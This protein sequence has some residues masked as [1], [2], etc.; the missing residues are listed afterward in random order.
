M[1]GIHWSDSWVEWMRHIVPELDGSPIYVRM[2][3]EMPHVDTSG[4]QACTHSN[5][6]LKMRDCLEERGQWLGRGG[7]ILV[8][9]DFHQ[10]GYARQKEVLLHELSHVVASWFCC[11]RR[12]EAEFSSAE[13]QFLVPGGRE[14][15]IDEWA[16]EIAALPGGAELLALARSGGDQRAAHD[17]KFVRVGLHLWH[18][19][20]GMVCLDGITLCGPDYQC[21]DVEACRVELAEELAVGGNLLEIVRSS[22][23]PNFAALFSDK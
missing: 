15:L 14:K 23:P 11:W 18:R 20:N 7:V 8:R 9:D 17:A 3:S 19:S 1:S 4:C 5:F 22:L 16:H 2:F 10:W 12:P 13:L 21:N 6:D